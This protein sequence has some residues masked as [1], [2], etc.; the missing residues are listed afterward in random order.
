V[1]RVQAYAVGLARAL[2]ID[3]EATIKALEA[4]A[5]LHDTGKLGVPEHIL[6]KPGGLTPAEFEQMKKHVD[7]GADILSLV[8]F[9][10]PVVPIVRCHHENWDGSGYPR[11]VAGEDIPIGARILSVVDCFDAL[12]SDRPYRRALTD[13]AA[14][15]ILMDRRGRMYDPRVVDTFVEIYRTIEVGTTEHAEQVLQLLAQ[16]KKE[17]APP[18]ALPV[19]AL[20]VASHANDDV[21][22]FVSLS[23]LASGAGTLGDML[24]LATKLV[25]NLSPDMSGAWYVLNDDAAHVMAVDAFGPWASAL[26]GRSIRV[27]DRLT[28]WVAAS[29]Q[30]IINSDAALDLGNDVPALK[31]CLSVPMM[32]GDTLVGVLSLYATARNAFSDDQGRLVQ[33]VAPHIATGIEVARRRPEQPPF[34]SARDL[35]LVSSR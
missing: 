8:D 7:I 10:Y 12:T 30:L 27:G 13:K 1:R 5:L 28:G 32:A 22:A 9:P 6:N 21:L 24:S 26:R 25:K 35:K 31:S 15:D 11:G 14:I 34:Q 29:R 4:A 23:R 33:M 16:S 19:P 18:S 3:D 17:A 20:Q 2:G